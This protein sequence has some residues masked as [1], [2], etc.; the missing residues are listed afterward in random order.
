MATL[1]LNLMNR[2]VRT[3]IFT[4]EPLCS[5]EKIPTLAIEQ[6]AGWAIF[7]G[8]CREERWAALNVGAVEWREGLQ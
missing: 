1:F 8:C 5:Q 2:W 7:T 3:L 4:P 6:K